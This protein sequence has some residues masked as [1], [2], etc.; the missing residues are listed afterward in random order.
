MLWEKIRKDPKIGDISHKDNT[1]VNMQFV[2][3][4]AVALI[5]CIALFM[6]VGVYQVLGKTLLVEP[7][8]M[9]V[10]EFEF[11]E[12]TDFE[13]VE[14][15]EPEFREVTQPEFAEV[16]ELEFFVTT[17]TSN[18][19]T[20]RGGEQKSIEYLMCGPLKGLRLPEKC[21]YKGR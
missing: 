6:S 15:T 21:V 14:I 13:F 16:T 11:M 10:T 1:V 7:E 3:G 12:V 20:V 17:T 5:I 4:V 2:A 8:F 9:E 19:V 18:G